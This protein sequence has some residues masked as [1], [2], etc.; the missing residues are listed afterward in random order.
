[1]SPAKYQYGAKSMVLD[2]W[3]S[4]RALP[5]CVQIWLAAFLVPVNLFPL[6]FLDQP[7]GHLIAL[8]AIAGMALNVPIMVAA[9]GMSGAIALPHVLCWVPLVII[10]TLLL[11]SEEFLS[12]AFVR[13]LWLLLIVD[14]TSLVF[15]FR[16]AAHWLKSRKAT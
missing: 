12:P 5:L 4:F 8:L 9:R 7:Q 14:I 11:M 3:R 13:F 16:D 10:V 1:M 15:D 2:I 6:A